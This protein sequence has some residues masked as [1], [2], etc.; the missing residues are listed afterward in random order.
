MGVVVKDK[1]KRWHKG[2]IP[3]VCDNAGA[4]EL[5]TDF[6]K[7]L[8]VDLFVARTNEADYVSITIGSAGNSEIGRKGGEQKLAARDGSKASL[9]HEMGH[10]AGMGHEYFHTKST[11]KPTGFLLENY[12]MKQADYKD[13]TSKYDTMSIMEYEGVA[14]EGTRD[15]LTELD[16]HTL[17]GLKTGLL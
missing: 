17:I 2:T 7:C 13:G 15:T 16:K 12:N 11:N 1:K 5:V 14:G 3:Y 8:G 9:W 6:N 10:A 4:K